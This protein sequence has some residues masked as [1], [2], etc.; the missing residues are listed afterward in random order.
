MSQF[1]G[2][3]PAMVTPL[4]ADGRPNLSAT[5]ALVEAFIGENLDGL[6]ITGST[7]QWPMLSPSDRRQVAECVV[8]TATGRI[9]V[10]VHVGCAATD[11]AVAL[12]RHSM[13]IGADA[14]SSVAP[15]YYGWTADHIFEHFRQ[16]GL[17]SEL[18]LFV[19][20]LSSVHQLALDARDYARRVCDLPR[21]EG[22]KITDRDLFQFGTIHHTA[23]EKLKLFSGADELLC[24]ATL[25]GSTG[26]IGTFYNVWGPACRTAR[27]AVI[28]GNFQ[29]GLEFMQAF[30]STLAEILASRSHWTF[31]QTAI[32]Q[33]YGVDVGLPRAPLAVGN[34]EWA[35]EEVERLI[36]RVNQA[37]QSID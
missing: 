7:G 19:Y 14:V 18:P 33:L 27:S 3:W 16:I 10:M 2:V 20:H 30:Q 23:G 29:A 6:Y 1:S 22:M 37:A 31:L 12:A 13:D 11:D 34:R 28:N 25:S 24:H 4:D 8:R 32:K 9:P 35:A 17:A 36:D 15:I 26:A 21:I 5:E